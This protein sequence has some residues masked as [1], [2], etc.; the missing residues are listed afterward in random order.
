MDAKTVQERLARIGK[1]VT[2]IGYEGAYQAWLRCGEEGWKVT[3]PVASLGP[4]A[5]PESALM[6]AE[7]Q[8]LSIARERVLKVD[9]QKRAMEALIRQVSD[10]AP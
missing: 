10:G 3:M 8:A 7:K 6:E 5:T 9:E 2:P 1:L 4:H